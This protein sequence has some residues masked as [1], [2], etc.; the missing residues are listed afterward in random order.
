MTFHYTDWINRDAYI[1]GLHLGR[2]GYSFSSGAKTIFF[3]LRVGLRGSAWCRC[4]EFD[5]QRWN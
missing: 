2:V 5:V 4:A 1:I 3:R